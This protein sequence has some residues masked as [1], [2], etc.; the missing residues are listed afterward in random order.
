MAAWTPAD[1]TTALWLDAADA[2]TITES[3]GDVSQWADKSGNSNHAVNAGSGKP[4]Y[5]AVNDRVVFDGASEYL[6]LTSQPFTGTTARTVFAV[7]NTQTR[8]TAGPGYFSADDSGS[9]G[10]LW[11]LCPEVDGFWIRISGNDYYTPTPG[12]GTDELLV[13]QWESGSSSNSAVWHDGSALSRAGGSSQTISTGTG[14]AHIGRTPGQSDVYYDGYI[15]ELIVITGTVTTETRQTVEG[16]LAWKWGT[17]G[18]L[19]GGHPY[20][21]FPPGTTDGY[22]LHSDG[23]LQPPQMLGAVK[24]EGYISHADGPLELPAI[25]ANHLFG[26]IS[27]NGPLE[28][29]AM[30]AWHQFG[31]ISHTAGPLSAN[32]QMLGFNDFVSTLDGTESIN[33]AMDLIASGVA[34]RVPIRSWQ[35]TYRLG[36]TGYLQAV[37]PN[38]G[39]WLSEITA[40]TS[41]SIYQLVTIDGLDIEY[42]IETGITIERKDEA[43]GATNYSVVIIGY[44]AAVTDPGDTIDAYDQTLLKQRSVFNNASTGYRVR[45]K[46]NMLLRPGNRA[47]VDDTNSYKVDYVTYYC[48]DSD[49]YMDVGE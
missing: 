48:F 14:T 37:I 23:P 34:T 30:L 4:S 12:E 47:W 19:P 13:A 33:Y 35:G 20:E 32:V 2:A 7:V 24:V 25:L 16:Y 39:E 3:G 43:Q 26:Y 40:A 11:D 5:D 22:I 31:Y 8:G 41:F 29:P 45:C 10:N 21:T 38:A 9:L 28:S 6:A 18:D 42:P 27:A 15:Y 46:V 17:E 49:S 36:Q 44:P 1:I